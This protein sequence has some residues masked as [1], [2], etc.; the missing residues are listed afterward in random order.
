MSRL[1]PAAALLLLLAGAWQHG[2]GVHV[3]WQIGAA[4]RNQNLNTVPCLLAFRTAPADCLSK[5]YTRDGDYVRANAP[6]LERWHLGPFTALPIS[7]AENPAQSEPKLPEVD[8]KLVE[9]TVDAVD[10]QLQPDGRLLVKA[11]GW[12]LIGRRETPAAVALTI[13]GVNAGETT[14]FLPRGDVSAFFNRELPPSG[15]TIEAT[16]ALSKGN[17]TVSAVILDRNGKTLGTLPPKELSW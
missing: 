3:G 10:F 17:H 13:D 8:P 4:N 5:L 7:A 16:L 15:W 9:G 12:S 11:Q 14:L 2:K 6:T 1:V